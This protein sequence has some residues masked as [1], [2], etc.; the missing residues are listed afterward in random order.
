MYYYTII[1]NTCT[2]KAFKHG[3]KPTGFTSEEQKVNFLTPRLEFMP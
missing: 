2:P 3:E 1:V